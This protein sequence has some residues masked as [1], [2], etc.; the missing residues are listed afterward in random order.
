M[1]ILNP[2]GRSFAASR[3][4]ILASL[5]G[6]LLVSTWISSF[7]SSAVGPRLCARASAPKHNAAETAAATYRQ[8]S[9]K[10]FTER[11]S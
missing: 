10:G 1:S 2:S 4:S 5:P 9:W 6:G 8:N 3:S 7:S 11:I